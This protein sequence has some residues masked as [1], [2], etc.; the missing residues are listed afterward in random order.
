[1]KRLLRYGPTGAALA[2]FLLAALAALNF[3]AQNRARQEDLGNRQRLLVSLA[4][5]LERL[6]RYEDTE[7]ALRDA[8]HRDAAPP[9]LPARFPA[10]SRREFRRLPTVGGWRG[11]QLEME[12][13]LIAT[14]TALDVAAFCATNPPAWRLAR[15][16]IDAL[17]TVGNSRLQ[18]TLERVEERGEE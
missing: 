18:L 3:R 1:M 7:L 10:P 2:G 14:R 6:D 16:Q 4:P 9:A 11:Q 5:E 13:P 15:L 17:D 8:Q 12:W